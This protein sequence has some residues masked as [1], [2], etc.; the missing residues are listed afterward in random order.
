M[1]RLTR[2]A[3]TKIEDEIGDWRGSDVIG[4]VGNTGEL[5]PF[6]QVRPP[7]NPYSADE[8]PFRQTPSPPRAIKPMY[9]KVAGAWFAN[10]APGFIGVVKDLWNGPLSPSFT[11]SDTLKYT[12]DSVPT[13]ELDDEV[14]K[15]VDGFFYKSFENIPSV[16]PLSSLDDVRLP[17]KSNPGFPAMFYASNRKSALERILDAGSYIRDILSGGLQHFWVVLGR[18][19]RTSRDVVKARAVLCP[20]TSFHSVA[21]MLIQPSNDVLTQHNE[22]LPIAV[23]ASIFNGGPDKMAKYL[24]ADSEDRVYFSIDVSRYDSTFPRWLYD[25][26]IGLRLMLLDFVNTLFSASTWTKL[27]RIIYENVISGPI[28]LSNYV[29]KRQH[30]M[31]SGWGGTAHDDSIGHFWLFLYGAATIV[32]SKFGADAITDFF[33]SVRLKISGDDLVGSVSTRFRPIFDSL[34]SSYRKVGFT[35]KEENF[36]VSD[37]LEGLTWCKRTFRRYGGRW[38]FWR[39]VSDFVSSLFYPDWKVG[40][41]NYA[42]SRLYYAA[43]SWRLENPFDRCTW[44]LSGSIGDTLNAMGVTAEDAMNW[45]NERVVY[46]GIGSG[47]HNYVTLPSLEEVEKAHGF[48]FDAERLS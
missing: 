26:V 1:G 5:L 7:T 30:G 40:S 47:V 23:G 31:P 42:L 29:L 12:G 46:R 33:R 38:V 36:C 44:S 8:L 21:S 37:D 3:L 14:V 9:S 25:R 45:I 2:L 28:I 48:R 22:D 13:D 15:E 4:E 32:K 19:A 35:V 17:S 20:D 39:P 18:S 16:K 41:R 6:S 24:M 43:T 34:I 11:F 10:F 27:L